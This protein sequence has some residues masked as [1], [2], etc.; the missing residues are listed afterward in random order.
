MTK[1]EDECEDGYEGRI[2]RR[3]R[4]VEGEDDGDGKEM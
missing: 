4:D 1:T 2:P 3:T